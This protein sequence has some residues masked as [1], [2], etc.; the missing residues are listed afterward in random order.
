MPDISPTQRAYTLRLRGVG[1]DETWRDALWATHEAVNKGAKVFGDWLL[2]LRGGIAH[3]LEVDGAKDHRKDRRILLALSWLSVEDAHGAPQDER[4]IVAKG[5]DP[6]P[7]RSRALGTA[8]NSIL[9]SQGLDDVEIGDWLRDCLPSLSAAIRDDAVWVNRSAAFDRLIQECPDL[10]RA[11]VWDFLN[12]FF[13]NPAAYLQPASSESD[14]ESEAGRL[15]RKEEKAKDLAQKARGWLSNRFGSGAGSDFAL[16]ARQYAVFAW[17]CRRQN[18]NSS[19]VGTDPAGELA[20][21]LGVVEVPERL[22]ATPGPPN[23]VQMTFRRISATLREGKEPTDVD[24]HALAKMAHAQAKAKRKL[25]GRKATRLWSQRMLA[26]VRDACGIPFRD[27]DAKAD[28]I[29]EYSVMLDHAARRAN[30]AHSWIKNAEAE[31]RQFEHDAQRLANVPANALDWLQ[32]YCKERAREFGSLDVYRIRRRA[33]DGWAKVLDRWSRADCKTTEDRIAAARELQDDPDIDKFGDIQLFEALAAE[34][35]TCVWKP[36]GTASAQPLAEFVAATDAEAK[37]GR[38]KVP[39]YR[40]PDALRHPI[41]TDYGNSRWHIDY[42]AHRAPAKRGELTRKVEKLTSDLAEI[43]RK[44]EKAPEARRDP[45]AKKADALQTTIQQANRELAA[46]ADRHRMEMKL[47][48]GRTVESVELRW[49]CKRLAKDICLQ[50]DDSQQ[51][52]GRKAVSRADRL[53]RAAAGADASE[54]LS[55]A[56]MFEQENW[57][58]RLQ[59]PRADLDAIA[60][61]VDKNGW[62]AKARAVVQRLPWLVSFSAEL[63]PRGPWVDYCRRF[64]DDA[65]ARPFISRDGDYAI[66]HRDNDRRAGQSRLLFSRLPGLRILSVDLGH[67]Y[68]AACAVWEAITT[69]QMEQ[70]CKA[71][72]VPSP[73]ADA[74]FVHL[75]GSNPAGKITTTVCRRIGPEVLSGGSA[76]P[77]PWAR[78]DRQFLI[79]LQ[80]EDRPARKASAKEIEAVEDFE[81]WGGLTRPD[82]PTRDVRVDRL[83]AD[84][85][86]TARLALARHARRARIAQPSRID[87]LTDTLAEWHSL[88][89]DGRW[90]DDCALRLWNQRVSE[91]SGGFRL[92]PCPA[93]EEAVTTNR[94]ERR[95]EHDALRKRVG[96][97]AELLAADE[98]LRQKLHEAWA[99]RWQADD[100]QWKH[101]LRWLARWL[102]PRGRARRDATG[103]RIGGLS[104]TRIASLTEFRRKVQVGFF[105]RMWPDGTRAE[106]GPRFGAGTLEAIRRLKDNRVKQLA[107]RLVEAALGV[108]VERRSGDGRDLPRPTE[109][110]EGARFAACHAVVIEDL[111]HYRPEETRSRRENRATMDWKSAETQKRLKDHCQLYGLSLRDVNP[112][113]TSRQDSRTGAPGFRCTDVPVDQFMSAP[114]WRKQVRAAEKKTR[115]KKGGSARDG[116]LLF[117]DEK[118]RNIPPE[119]WKD[120]PPLRIPV[121]GGE[122][123]VSADHDSP[124]AKGIQADLNA[125]ANIG[126]RALM[127]PDFAGKWWYVPCD[128]KTGK[129]VAEK[130][131][132]GIL[133]KVGP[134]FEPPMD[135]KSEQ[136]KGKRSGR[137]TAS[138][139]KDVVNRWRDPKCST[140]RGRLGGEEWQET[141]AYWNSCSRGDRPANHGEEWQETTAYWNG[142]QCRVIRLLTRQADATRI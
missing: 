141:T 23:R 95:E 64:G 126:L 120:A 91:L 80:G 94:A 122:L 111:S 60:R 79:K 11:E 134:L 130:V 46:L 113:Y 102:M 112:Q 138:K 74:M 24:Y 8:L 16:V 86:R 99:A 119:K 142:A 21:M 124:A 45:L 13:A 78:L 68:A 127:D 103:W 57:N 116:Y 15:D 65:P 70:A 87:V 41:F 82:A 92:Q 93:A 58:G 56:G 54:A 114:W 48:T 14:D 36:G 10:T 107:S 128:P 104:L 121:N 1:N 84:A 31:R 32:D 88:A 40:H 71:A 115:E 39:C 19:R 137:K 101:R 81:R 43:R 29:N 30:V 77:A 6:A 66:A 38:F 42:C 110:G 12:P 26:G 96:P 20:R 35:A 90:L 108:G 123:F 25:V 17:W 33:I 34:A 5:T 7:C 61:R 59:A 67:R 85:V 129:P 135:E 117:L 100:E 118:C 139:H 105:T 27:T 69:E 89:T 52:N 62:D 125:A 97:L 18:R 106:I 133:E 63:T 51:T 4:L 53:G 136:S 72:G 73:S 131:K 132:G 3:H 47:W 109:Q 49:S 140:I 76:H 37:R 44:H 55:I 98:S 28:L 75:V 50:G 22:A 9:K 2:T 83:M